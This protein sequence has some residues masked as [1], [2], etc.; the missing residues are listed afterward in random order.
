MK[1]CIA[2]VFPRA[3]AETLYALF[4]ILTKMLHGCSFLESAGSNHSMPAEIHPFI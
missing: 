1:T 3:G 4:F 2:Q